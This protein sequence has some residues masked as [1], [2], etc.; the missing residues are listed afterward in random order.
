MRF[1]VDY[2]PEHWDRARWAADARLMKEAGFNVVRMGEFAWAALEPEEGKWDFDWLDNAVGLL[3]GQG[4]DTVLGTPTA[5]PPKWMMDRYPDI[6]PRDMYGRVKGFGNRRHC[7]FNSPSFREQ[8]RRVVTAMAGHYRDNPHVIGWQID[9]ELMGRCYCENCRQ[10]FIRWLRRKYGTLERLNAEWGTV[11]WSQTYRRWEE[12]ILPGYSACGISD[13]N[14]SVHNPGL[15]LDYR[16]FC[17][18]SI[19][20]YAG[21]QA[22]ILHRIG[23]K[24]V[25]HNVMP[26][27]EDVDYHRMGRILDFASWDNYPVSGFDNKPF[28]WVSMGHALTR[29]LNPR[30]FWLMEQQ[31]GPCG[32]GNVG[33]TPKPGQLRLWTLQSLANGAGGIVY[34]RW[35]A[36]LFGTE[37]YWYGILDHDGIPRRRYREIQAVGAELKRAGERLRGGRIVAETAVVYSY[38]ILWAHRV[39]GHNPQFDYK[40]MVWEQ[41]DSLVRGAFGA[42]VIGAEAD[43][44]RYRAVFMPA[45]C[46]TAEAIGQKAEDYVRRGGT[47]VLTYRSGI[48]RG[49]GQMTAETLP[50]EFRRLAGARVEEFDSLNFGRTVPVHGSMGDFRAH[51]W[52]D[53]LRPEGAQSVAAYAGEYYAGTPAIVRNRLGQGTVYYVGCDMEETA[54]RKFTAAVCRRAGAAPAVPVCPAGLETVTWQTKAGRLLFLLNHSGEPMEVP[55]AAP[56]RDILRDIP[57]E[58][59]PAAVCRLPAFGVAVLETQA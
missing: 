9:N 19:L 50:G 23:G 10:A 24:P 42:D 3:A 6:Y 31:S 12:L 40:R 45:F 30:P 20:E 34:F 25:T 35:R 43:F 47:L 15:E 21:M 28:T 8:S 49:N 27:A 36:C 41:Y 4:M 37:Q 58:S 2:Y 29:G 55:L 14:R 11:F 54:R 17:S 57:A 46:M 48:K 18:D 53:L 7:C 56:C 13:E 32:W 22:K 44:S 38:D 5:A 59:E 26:N 16:R 52:C 51:V 1:G 39:Q 33:D